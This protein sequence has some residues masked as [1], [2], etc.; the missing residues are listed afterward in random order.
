MRAKQNLG[1]GKPVDSEQKKKRK[2]RPANEMAKEMMYF[3]V[4]LNCSMENELWMDGGED[5]I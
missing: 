1:N 3:L 2:R 4:D 5:D